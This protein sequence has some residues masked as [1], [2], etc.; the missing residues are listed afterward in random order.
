MEI[1]GDF[2]SVK[3]FSDIISS[4]LIIHYLKGFPSSLSFFY[5]ANNFVIKL[6]SICSKQLVVIKSFLNFEQ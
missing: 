6:I 5:T 1:N 4:I 3:M 2:L